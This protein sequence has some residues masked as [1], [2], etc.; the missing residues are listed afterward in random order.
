MWYT[1]TYDIYKSDKYASARRHAYA[2]YVCICMYYV[3]I[4]TTPASL[5][6]MPSMSRSTRATPYIC[7]IY[8]CIYIHTYIRVY[9]HTHV[10]MYTCIHSVGSDAIHVS[11]HACYAICMP[12]THMSMYIYDSLC[13]YV[14]TYTTHCVCMYLHICVCM[15]V[16]VWLT[17]YRWMCMHSMCMYSIYVYLNMYSCYAMYMPHMCIYMHVQTIADRVAQHLEIVSIEF[18]FSTRR[19]RILMGFIIYYLVLIVNPMGRI[20]VR[21]KHLRSNLETLCHPICSCLY[22]YVLLNM[23]VL[24]IYVLNVC[25]C[26][27]H[28]CTADCR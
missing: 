14:F 11:E 1:Y 6:A 25:V 17:V 19:T 26:S 27:R 15:Y 28:A 21:W 2:H 9:I 22:V 23:H 5:E 18:Q 4:S 13:M 3:Y 24:N 10:H 7:S 16:H 12:H 20:L 8:I